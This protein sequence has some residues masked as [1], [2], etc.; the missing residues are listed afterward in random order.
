MA[1]KHFKEVILQ[2][3]VEKFTA[4]HYCFGKFYCF[5]N[6]E[7]IKVVKASKIDRVVCNEIYYKPVKWFLCTNLTNLMRRTSVFRNIG[8][9]LYYRPL[10]EV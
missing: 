1:N 8:K 5:N 6:L 4:V 10:K 3:E 7:L 9:I 2:R